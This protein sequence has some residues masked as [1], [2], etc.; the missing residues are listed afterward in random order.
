VEVEVE[1]GGRRQ[2][3]AI[4]EAWVEEGE[5]E[6]GTFKSPFCSCGHMTVTEYF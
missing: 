2:L 4:V 6:S 1:A 5:K 3:G